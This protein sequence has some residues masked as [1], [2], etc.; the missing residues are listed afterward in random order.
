[1]KLNFC[2]TAPA[3]E[4]KRYTPRAA[5]AWP[6]PETAGHGRCPDRTARSLLRATAREEWLIRQA[7]S[8][9]AMCSAASLPRWYARWTFGQLYHCDV[10]NMLR[11]WQKRAAG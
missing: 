7:E 9:L 4:K 2:C 3:P 6:R 10:L 1:M 11:E 5:S 8:E